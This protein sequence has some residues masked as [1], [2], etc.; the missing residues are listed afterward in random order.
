MPSIIKSLK[1]LATLLSLMLFTLALTANQATAASGPRTITKTQRAG[2]QTAQTNPNDNTP[3]TFGEP[4]LQIEELS[5][6]L[7]SDNTVLLVQGKLIN[8]SHMPVKGYVLVKILDK[9]DNVITAIETE[10]NQSQ[11]FDHGEIKPF[12][13]QVDVSEI[14][15][16][17]NVAIEFILL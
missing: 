13:A 6:K 17:A 16:L 5:A 12:E 10:I 4:Q 11:R 8:N 1:H 14:K 9:S 2:Q 3:R 7:F 15:G